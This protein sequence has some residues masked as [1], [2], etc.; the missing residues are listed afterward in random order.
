M[1]S[2][3]LH[4]QNSMPACL[5]G[6][7]F[8]LLP[9]RRL[10][11]WCCCSAA[12]AQLAQVQPQ[13][14]AAALQRRLASFRPRVPARSPEQPILP[15]DVPAGSVVTPR[16]PPPTRSRPASG[17]AA[18]PMASGA[19]TG[20]PVGFSFGGPAQP[21]CAKLEPTAEGLVESGEVV[22]I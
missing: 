12:L 16:D 1:C 13:M 8:C 6:G 9:A 11:V 14:R 3:R 21:G 19:D 2:A 15:L 17:G 4:V 5:A 7:A 22:R 10:T 18:L 20:G